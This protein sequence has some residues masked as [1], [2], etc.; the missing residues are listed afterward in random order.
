MY[1]YVCIKYVY[2][3]SSIPIMYVLDMYVDITC[4]DDFDCN[5]KNRIF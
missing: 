1:V 4:N 2:K 5:A 3:K